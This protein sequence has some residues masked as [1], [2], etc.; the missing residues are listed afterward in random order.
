[1]LTHPHLPPHLCCVHSLCAVPCSDTVSFSQHPR[2]PPIHLFLRLDSVHLSTA[3]NT[4][5]FILGPVLLGTISSFLV[6][7]ELLLARLAQ[8]PYPRAHAALSTWFPPSPHAPIPRCTIVLTPALHPSPLCRPIF[9]NHPLFVCYRRSPPSSGTGAACL[10]RDDIL[11]LKY[12][13]YFIHAGVALLALSAAEL[14]MSELSR[15]A[16]PSPHAHIPCTVSLYTRTL[17]NLCFQYVL[18]CFRS[19]WRF[20]SARI[21]GLA[22]LLVD[23]LSLLCMLSCLFFLVC[24]LLS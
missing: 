19:G 18:R 11:R 16:T 21:I 7:L 9:C 3:R 8:L 6:S 10:A 23:S 5:S 24:P 1:M 2:P 15:A 14:R 22:Y 17:F 13:L 12:R 20:L 4:S